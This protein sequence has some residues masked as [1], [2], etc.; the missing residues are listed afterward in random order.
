MSSYGTL[1]RNAIRLHKLLLFPLRVGQPGQESLWI[2]TVAWTNITDARGEKCRQSSSCFSGE[3]LSAPFA[4]KAG[5]HKKNFVKGMDKTGCGFQYMRN[6]FPN[7][8]DA[9]TRRVYL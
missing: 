5:P 6:K 4:Q 7:V 2:L 8:S 3:H 1:T 9:K